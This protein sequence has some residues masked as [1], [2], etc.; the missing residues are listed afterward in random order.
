MDVGKFDIEHRLD[1]A[2]HLGADRQDPARN[3]VY[4]RAAE[5]LLSK[6]AEQRHRRL[7]MDIEVIVRQFDHIVLCRVSERV[8]GL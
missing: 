2:R 7:G 4:Q 8:E 3:F 1:P 6:A 5:D